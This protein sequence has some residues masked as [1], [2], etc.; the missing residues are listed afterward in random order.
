MGLFSDLAGLFQGT[1]GDISKASVGGQMVDRG[2]G[3]GSALLV[4]PEV[5]A[6]A[7]TVYKEK[8]QPVSY[9]VLRYLCRRDT[10]LATIIL[11]RLRQVKT[12]ARPRTHEEADR[13]NQTG[14]RV[15]MKP[16]A[17][18]RTAAV[19]KT[20]DD[21]NRFIARCGRED[22]E[23]HELG[24]GSFLW[25]FT[26]DRL[27]F[28]QACAEIRFDKKNTPV[29]FFAVDGSSIRIID[30]AKREKAG[31]A[32]IQLYHNR[33]VASF[34]EREMMF[35][36]ENLTTQIE[37]NGYSV[38]ET[39]IAIKKVMAHLGIDECNS[40]QFHPGSM[41]KG[42]FALMNAD[43]SEDQL[44]TLE[45]KYKTQVANYRGRHRIPLLPIPRG[46]NL[47]FIHLPQANDIEFGNFLDFLYNTLTGLFG[48]D[49]TEINFPNRGGGIGGASPA[50]IS[51]SPEATRLTA[52]RDKGLR[53]LLAFLEDCI[54]SELMP[55]LDATGDFEFSFIGFDR[56]TEDDRLK[57]DEIKS[58]TYMT[59]NEV[60]EAHGLEPR[61]DCDVIRDGT[62]L[63][64]KMQEQMAQQQEQEGGG[65]GEEGQW[66]GSEQGSSDEQEGWGVPEEPD[67]GDLW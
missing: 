48:M 63:Q 55:Y 59:V 47:Q 42:L 11:T 6:V 9:N 31:A 28:D 14:Y 20:E 13:T 7:G 18:E 66:T 25:K 61:D 50:L 33:T 35:C 16:G 53:T 51:S 17:G 8:P 64:A 65:E 2:R 26:R 1:V 57:Q 10:I 40:R 4:D 67:E 39:E 12:F 46:G 23:P 43:M 34:L 21:L 44:Q 45:A 5:W 41:P 60:R 52:S 58:R 29:E 30:P 15:R 3:P 54:N 56:Q 37:M 36:P 24:F 32:Y 19:E 49:P 62:W 38:S 27:E 22:V